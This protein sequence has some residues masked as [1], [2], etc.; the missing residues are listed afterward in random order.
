MLLF[1][2]AA[3]LF[4]RNGAIALWDQDEAAYAGFALRMVKTGDWL[5]PNF[6]WSAIHQKPPLQFWAIATAYQTL[7]I[8]EFTARLPGSLAILATG[9]SFILLGRGLWR[10]SV[11]AIAA[12]LCWSSLLLP[13]LAKVAL[14]DGLLVWLETVAMLSWLQLLRQTR[15]HWQLWLWGAVGLGL[16]TK[17]P[18]I[19]A[20]VLGSEL[21]LLGFRCWPL[22]RR[23][24][25]EG[26]KPS[27]TVW[28][29]SKTLMRWAMP[30]LRKVHA[31]SQPSTTSPPLRRGEG[32]IATVCSILQTTLTRWY[33]AHLSL[34]PITLWAGL[35]IQRDGGEYLRTFLDFYLFKRLAGETMSGQTGPP[36]YYAG[37]L[38]IAFLP[39]LPWL[40]GAMLRLWQERR[41]HPEIWAWLIAGWLGYELIPSKLPSYMLGAYPAIALLIA[42]QVQQLQPAKIWR[43]GIGSFS[44]LNLLVAGGLGGVAVWL[45]SLPLAITTGVWLVG[46]VGLMIAFTI[47]PLTQGGRGDSSL[48]TFHLAT[49]HAL[50]L[51][52][53][54]WGWVLPSWEF[55]HNAPNRLAESAIATL[56]PNET[57]TLAGNFDLPSI[58][59]YLEQQGQ[60]YTVLDGAP[61]EICQQVQPNGVWI[62]RADGPTVPAAVRAEITG[63]FGTLGQLQ[64]YQVVD[65]AAFCAR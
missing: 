54:L 17:G 37:I 35:T 46:T 5:L 20:L 64:T 49:T 55:Q 42:Q 14:T 36:G 25:K 38:A 23:T 31:R 6:T 29:G 12:L 18:P 8:S 28:P 16:L 15:W 27:P 24:L 3:F 60:D 7:G 10:L 63:W 1:W 62:V 47:T 40:I 4:W 13:V 41:A 19:L 45:R 56:K 11:R 2:S 9:L 22:V 21:I 58:P 43:W 33:I 51:L 32:G 53:L 65:A 44:L 39:W 57:L 50:L 34:L 48:T 52:T 26:F 61:S 59:F 30:T